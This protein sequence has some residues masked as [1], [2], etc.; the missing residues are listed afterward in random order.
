VGLEFCDHLDEYAGLFTR[1]E[2]A[3]QLC[4]NLVDRIT[5]EGP[6]EE[7]PGLLETALVEWQQESR[8]LREAFLE[9]VTSAQV[10]IPPARGGRRRFDRKRTGNPIC[11]ACGTRIPRLEYPE[12]KFGLDGVVWYRGETMSDSAAAPIA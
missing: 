12:W 3:Y 10:T 4:I 2:A 9:L 5:A 8:L 6:G 7:L 1:A 11:T